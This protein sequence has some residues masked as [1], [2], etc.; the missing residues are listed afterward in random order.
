MAVIAIIGAG[1]IGSQVARL[2]VKAGHQVV[3]AN[4]RGGEGLEPLVD[5]LGANARP[6]VT[7][8]DATERADV[9]VVAMPIHSYVALPADAFGGKIVIDTG[10]YYPG[11][12][13]NIAELDNESTTTAEILQ[14]LL[15]G[16]SVVKALNHVVAAEL[17]STGSP[18]GS[19]DR[20]AL[21]MAGDDTDAKRVVQSLLDSFGFDVVDVGPLSEGW[22]FQRD[23]PAYAVRLDAAEMRDALAG[24]VRYRDLP[25]N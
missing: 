9:V 8:A 22:R 5:E 14:R 1:N 2:A 21:A 13:G 7:V 17:T 16:A 19:E 20:R 23:L 15:P 6:A 4:S 12:N 3:L 24:A 11:W 10:N 18:A 25:R